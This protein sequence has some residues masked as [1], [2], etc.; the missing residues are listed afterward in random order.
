[1]Y[2]VPDTGLY[3]AFER[4]MAGHA[5]DGQALVLFD[6]PRGKAK[7]F[8]KSGMGEIQLGPEAIA[9]LPH[10]YNLTSSSPDASVVPLHLKARPGISRLFAVDYPV[11]AHRVNE[12]KA[13]IGALPNKDTAIVLVSETDDFGED[14]FGYRARMYD[15]NMRELIRLKTTFMEPKSPL[16]DDK[17]LAA[18]RQ[19][20]GHKVYEENKAADAFIYGRPWADLGANTPQSVNPFVFLTMEHDEKWHEKTDAELEILATNHDTNE[21]YVITVNPTDGCIRIFNMEHPRHND[22]R[23]GCPVF[24]FR[25]TDTQDANIKQTAIRISDPSVRTLVTS[26]AKLTSGS[27]NSADQTP[28]EKKAADEKLL[29]DKTKH[30]S[31][32]QKIWVLIVK[33]DAGKRQKSENIFRAIG[34]DESRY[35]IMTVDEFLKK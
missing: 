17:V 9:A 6:K 21:V 32:Y 4:L 1:V 15:K 18:V 22:Q 30:Y 20:V 12:L 33:D 5:E 16:I 7:T 27:G 34:I 13:A 23:Y 14:A 28:E 31:A 24:E 26:F 25:F 10:S 11:N 19:V 8:S 2:H 3:D 29:A 35:E